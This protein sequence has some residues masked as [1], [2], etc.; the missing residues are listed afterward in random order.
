MALD[1]IARFVEW[2]NEARKAHAP[3]PEA[4]ALATADRAGSPSVRM[5][6]LAS[7]DRRGLVFYAHEA[8]R[9]GRDLAARPRLDGR[10]RGGRAGC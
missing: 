9:K 4:M 1:P 6:L 5:V 2:L 7:V 10:I 8:S 3:L